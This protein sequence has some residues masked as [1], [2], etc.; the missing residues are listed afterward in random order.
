[1]S[2]FSPRRFYGAH[3]RMVVIGED[4]AKDGLIK[5]TDFFSRKSEFRT[6]FYIAVAK[7]TTAENVLKVLT[8]IEQI[9]ANS[10]FYSLKNSEVR[11][12]PSLGISL[13]QLIT[14]LTYDGREPVLTG[15][16]IVGEQKAGQ[17]LKNIEASAPNTLLQYV[18]LAMFKGDTLVGWLTPEESKGVTY[19]RDKVEN[20]IAIV[21]CSDG[22][23]LASLEVEH[24][25]A[26]VKGTVKNGTPKITV[27]LQLEA[28]VGEV[29]CAINF[30][31]RTSFI[32]LE[33]NANKVL[34]NLVTASIQK[35]QEYQTDV[36]GFGETIYQSYPAYWKKNKQNWD[37]IFANMQIDVK[38]NTKIKST[39]RIQNPYQNN[40]GNTK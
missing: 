13:H 15:I 23:G 37:E 14:D 27:E 9:P 25:E 32:R 17:T 19:I 2:T 20:T 21:P 35:A 7:G 1:M 3:L 30:N 31:E 40:E 8:P 5:I 11:W 29:Q 22:D 36:F 18:G 10:L 39:G 24:A 16:R 34:H 33:Q 38:V 28:I 6:D 12:A 26:S 4:A